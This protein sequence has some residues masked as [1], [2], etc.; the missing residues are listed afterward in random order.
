M[1]TVVAVAETGRFQDAA[2]DLS[3]TQQAVSKRIAALERH[4]GVKLF[5]RTP[6][7]AEPT[8]EGRAFLPHARELV[9][10]AE[11]ATAAVRSGARPLR[12]DVIGRRL[13]PA[14]LLRDF[15]RA[16]PATAVDVV[17]LFDVAAAVAAV[18]A[19]DVDA[20][21]RAV[22]RPARLPAD[23]VAVRVYDEPVQ[24]LTG[25]AHELGRDA[26][27]PPRRLAGQRIW[28][29]GIVA[30]TEWADYYTEFAAAFGFDLEVAGPQFGAEPLLDT[31]AGSCE[32]AT[33]V[34][35]RTRVF[36]PERWALRRIPLRGP[37]PVYPHSLLCRRD[38]PHPALAALRGHLAAAPGG[39]AGETWTPRWASGTSPALPCRVRG[40][41]SDVPG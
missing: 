35:E 27:V 12:V 19:G 9:R 28:M 13:A 2:A 10:V 32:L 17:T 7:G 11:R 18:R 21:F 41:G 3:I 29:P 38:N 24:L 25:P 40:S 39:G 15:Q 30:G 33:L 34:G 16:H 31:V 36:W 14:G 26:A 23:V 22:P 1:R 37:T 6:R 5:A 20:A 8:V 4:L